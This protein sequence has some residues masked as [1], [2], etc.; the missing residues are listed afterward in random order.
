[1]FQTVE[2]AEQYFAT[3][4]MLN[5]FCGEYTVMVLN[6]VHKLQVLF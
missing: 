6:F 2:Q 4:I 1:M 5:R 3:L